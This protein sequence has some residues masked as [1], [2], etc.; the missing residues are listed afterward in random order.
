MSTEITVISRIRKSHRLKVKGCHLR[1]CVLM[2]KP[3]ERRDRGK[4]RRAEALQPEKDGAALPSPIHYNKTSSRGF[5]F[6]TTRKV[7]KAERDRWRKEVQKFVGGR[8]PME[9]GSR[10]GL[11]GA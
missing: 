9:S 10:E 1:P 6:L 5:L 2:I 7:P 8:D 11:G 4:R 3:R